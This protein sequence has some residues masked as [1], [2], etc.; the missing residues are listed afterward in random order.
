MRADVAVPLSTVLTIIEESWAAFAELMAWLS[1]S[2]SV[3]SRTRRLGARRVL[4]M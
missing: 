3:S 1:R 2:G 4:T